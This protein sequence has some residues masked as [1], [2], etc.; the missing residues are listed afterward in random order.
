MKF[1]I[2]KTKLKVGINE[3]RSLRPKLTEL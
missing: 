1:I 2:G 3:S